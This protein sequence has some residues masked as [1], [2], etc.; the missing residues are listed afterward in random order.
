M[1]AGVALG[2]AR[3]DTPPM[4]SQQQ[5][6]PPSKRDKRR[7]ALQEKYQDLT[8]TF[9]NSRDAQFRQTVHELQN[10]MALIAFAYVS[11]TAPLS[12]SPEDVA[13]Q[14]Q[15]LAANNQ[16]ISDVVP[17]GR[18][19]SRFVQEVNKMKEERDAELVEVK[20]CLYPPFA[21]DSSWSDLSLSEL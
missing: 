1:A 21:A 7:N 15:K 11:D 13:Q 12:D 14:L 3:S 9:A 17:S 16:I 10:E 6:Q 5:Q 8:E 2:N 18:W 4:N 19:Y 20:V